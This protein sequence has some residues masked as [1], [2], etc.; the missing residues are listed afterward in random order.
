MSGMDFFIW[1]LVI[2]Y[3]FARH[4]LHR[5]NNHKRGPQ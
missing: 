4:R 1:V 5:R 3:A 2:G